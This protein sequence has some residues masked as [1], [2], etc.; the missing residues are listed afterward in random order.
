MA[1]AFVLVRLKIALVAAGLRKAGIGVVLGTLIALATAVSAGGMG[2]VLFGLARFMSDQAAMEAAVGGFGVVLLMWAL[3]PI[4]TA[5]SDGTL[6]ADR[7]TVFPLSARQLMPGLLG[8]ALAGFGGLATVLAFIGAF[9]GLTPLSPLAVLTVLAI[10]L[11]LATCAT[12]GRL[13]GTVISGAARTRRWRDVALFAG[14]SLAFALNLVTQLAFQRTRSSGT[15]GTVSLD[16]NPIARALLV[17]ARLLPSGPAAMAAGFA[18][19]GRALPAV[20][21]LAAGALVL[22]A[23]LALW[24]AALERTLSS[25]ASG[26]SARARRRGA[27]ARPRDLYPALLAWALPRN[28]IGAVAA[29]ELRALGRDPRQRMAAISGVLIVALMLTYVHSTLLGTPAS[30]LFAMGAAYGATLTAPNVYGFDGAAHWMNVAAGEDVRSDIV[31]KWL[32]QF[33]VI[34]PLVGVVTSYLVWRAGSATYLVP[35]LG[36]AFAVTATS[37]GIGAVLSVRMPM[38]MPTSKTNVFST[39]NAGRGA[40][41][42]LAGTV[43]LAAQAVVIGPLVAAVLLVDGAAVKAVVTVVAVALGVAG[44]R[45]GLRYAVQWSS[46]RQP[47]LLAALEPK[48]T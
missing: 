16:D 33:V 46:P 26:T 18:R 10:A 9:V 6:D 22:F 45:A 40:A 36:L 44:A 34:V 13:L 12:F 20:A 4:V 30:V 15:P 37:L 28:R 38:P 42:A 2:G 17:T 8:A 29:K 11:E 24:H 48:Q 21:A 3:G 35:A 47:E 7:L 14:P 19:A 1:V 25:A 31:G 27:S 39:G 32:A 23:G 43:A 41:S 5:T